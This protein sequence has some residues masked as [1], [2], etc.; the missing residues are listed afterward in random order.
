[1]MTFPEFRA[2][3]PE[4]YRQRVRVVIADDSLLGRK[5]L[6]AL[7][8]QP[9]VIA[10]AAC[11][12]TAPEL[13]SACAEKAPDVAVVDLCLPQKGDGLAASREIRARFPRLPILLVTGHEAERARAEVKASGVVQGY[14]LK[15][16]SDGLLWKC[17]LEVA[18]GQNAFPTHK[19]GWL[20][21]ELPDQTKLRQL[22]RQSV[23]VLGA[24]AALPQ[25]DT[26]QEYG[27][28]KELTR[29]HATHVRLGQE[30]HVRRVLERVRRRLGMRSVETARWFKRVS[31][32]P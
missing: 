25:I 14:A 1:M 19:S 3:F 9:P 27:L 28:I 8:R 23:E 21:L 11:V 4:L 32:L 30:G 15:N 13:L 5:G 17:V 31:A 7:L 18:A 29:V 12:G 20:A 24:L 2:C 6:T 10:V 26:A 16:Y 22:D